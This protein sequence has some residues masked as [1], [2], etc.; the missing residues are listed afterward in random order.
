[1]KNFNIALLS[2]FLFALSI[3]PGCN[4][5]E[6]TPTDVPDTTK[7]GFSITK[8]VNGDVFSRGDEILLSGTLTDDSEL[9]KLTISVAYNTPV[10]Y[11]MEKGVSIVEPEWEPA[12]S[13][14]TV[15]GTTKDFIDHSVFAIPMDILS[16]SYTITVIVEDVAGNKFTQSIDITITE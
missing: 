3:F 15:N 4:G 14:I 9:K 16:G 2:V 8:P 11:N 1:M 10:A 5:G 6:E 7:P 13:E 12:N